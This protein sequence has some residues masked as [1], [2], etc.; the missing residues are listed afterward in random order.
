MSFLIFSSA[1]FCFRAK[2]VRGKDRKKERERERSK[3]TFYIAPISLCIWVKNIVLLDIS[4]AIA[5]ASHAWH[6]PASSV[7]WTYPF[8]NASECRRAKE[9]PVEMRALRSSP[10]NPPCGRRAR[11]PSYCCQI[12]QK[13]ILKVKKD[14]K[15]ECEDLLCRW[16]SFIRFQLGRSKY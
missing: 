12:S 15:F 1:H 5:I 13:T 3:I 2:Q 14:V 9:S 4:R 10:E 6:S 11:C 8:S 16:S 7:I